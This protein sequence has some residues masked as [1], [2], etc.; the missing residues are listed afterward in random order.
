MNIKCFE[1]KKC[2]G[3]AFSRDLEKKKLNLWEKTAVDKSVW[4]K[5]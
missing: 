5:A 3:N 1:V 2:V 4:I